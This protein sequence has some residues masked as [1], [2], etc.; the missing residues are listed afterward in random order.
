MDM[1]TFRAVL[2]ANKWKTCLMGII[3]D[4]SMRW[5][6]DQCEKHYD[7]TKN[8]WVVDRYI[9]PEETLIFDD[10]NECIK[11]KEKFQVRD[12]TNPNA[13]K[14]FFYTVRPIGCVQA[15]I[16]CDPSNTEIRPFFDSQ[17]M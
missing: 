6:F 7:T 16:F 1:A 3:F 14:W 2:E 11:L 4:N 17:Y 10:A 8:Q 9:P 15:I 12:L 13:D 5:T